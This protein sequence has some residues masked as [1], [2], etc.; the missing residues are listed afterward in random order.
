MG[1][2]TLN[3]VV[4]WSMSF[5]PCSNQYY[6]LCFIG[7]FYLGRS[8]HVLL[9]MKLKFIK[10]NKLFSSDNV[11]LKFQAVALCHCKSMLIVLLKS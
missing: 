5:N 7:D 4:V 2:G 1:T 10:V 6:S 3:P 8:G 11:K 9:S